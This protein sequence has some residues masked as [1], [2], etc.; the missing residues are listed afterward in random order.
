VFENSSPTYGGPRVRNPAPSSG[1]VFCGNLNFFSIR[2]APAPPVESGCQATF[3][4]RSF[5]TNPR[6][7]ARIP[8]LRHQTAPVNLGPMPFSPRF[9]RRS[10]PAAPSTNTSTLLRNWAEMA[11]RLTADPSHRPIAAGS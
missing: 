1:E 5:P 3:K 9:P 8:T 10:H 2:G 11:A 7:V 6:Q 4:E